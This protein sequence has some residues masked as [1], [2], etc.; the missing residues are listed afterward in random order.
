MSWDTEHHVLWV[1]S[2]WECW[3]CKRGWFCTVVP[4]DD[5]VACP[6]W[7]DAV[8]TV[9][10][11]LCQRPPVTVTRVRVADTT[12]CTWGCMGSYPPLLTSLDGFFCFLHPANCACT[13][14]T[15]AHMYFFHH[16]FLCLSPKFDTASP[17]N[18]YGYTVTQKKLF[19][20]NICSS[21]S[22]LYSAVCE[23]FW[24]FISFIFIS[25]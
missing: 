21:T 22:S 13:C 9:I 3:G 4:G 10:C 25:A 8:C 23:A 24:L 20:E 15:H 5:G 18:E 14:P 12:Q 1:Q 7:R 6:R 17:A 16:L 2:G 19:S 11:P